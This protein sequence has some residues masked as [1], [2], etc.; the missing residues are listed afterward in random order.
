[1]LGSIILILLLLL[2][3]GVLFLLDLV[4][5][6]IILKRPPGM[7]AN[8]LVFLTGLLV[9]VMFVNLIV[10]MIRGVP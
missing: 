9:V 1:M 6:G 4:V 3:F 8:T 5:E 2:S 7:I 10:S